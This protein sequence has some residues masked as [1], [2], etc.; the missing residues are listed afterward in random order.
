MGLGGQLKPRLAVQVNGA[1]TAEPAYTTYEYGPAYSSFATIRRSTHT[2]TLVI[3]VLARY[4]LTRQLAHRFQADVLGWFSLVHFNVRSDAYSLDANQQ[5]LPP[6]RK[7]QRYTSICAT[8]GAGVRFTLCSRLEITGEAVLNHQLTSPTVGQ[9]WANPNLS[10]GLRY[11]F[12]L[13]D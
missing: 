12:G 3:P 7:S 11:R 8:L 4:T 5:P 2:R 6:T 1:Y 10:T 9:Y 13:R